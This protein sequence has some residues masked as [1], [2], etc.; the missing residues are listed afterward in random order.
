MVDLR[1]EH[2]FSQGLQEVI[3]FKEVIFQD[4]ALFSI[5]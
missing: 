4:E 5:T 1:K 2:V 3:S